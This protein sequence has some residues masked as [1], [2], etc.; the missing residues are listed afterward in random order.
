MGAANEKQAAASQPRRHNQP[1]ETLAP[2][3]IPAYKT[4]SPGALKTKAGLEASRPPKKTYRNLCKNRFTTRLVN[5]AFT[6]LTDKHAQQRTEHGPDG[7][8]SLSGR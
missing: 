5:L 4:F 3:Y 7:E 6:I 1:A 8:N 2:N